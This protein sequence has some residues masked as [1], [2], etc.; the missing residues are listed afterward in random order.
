MSVG[1]TS[2][3]HSI[4][5][6]MPSL[7][8]DPGSSGGAIAGWMPKTTG[9]ADKRFPEYEH[10]RTTLKQ[11]WNTSY[12]RQ[13]REHDLTRG[14]ITPFRAVNNAG[15]LLSR[16]NYACHGQG[17]SAPT[18]RPNLRGLSQRIGGGSASCLP[19]VV[20]SSDQLL[21]TIPASACNVKYVYDSSDYTTYRKQRA[22][23]GNYN[24]LSTGGNQHRGAQT[25]QRAI[26]RG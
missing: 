15:D 14:I 26:R 7:I 10:I 22:M 9:S 18:S 13:L 3:F 20:Y 23:A 17:L 2:A 11:A 21:H 4:S 24:A 1:Y 12:R 16:Q 6:I 25:V 5:S 8:A 19:S